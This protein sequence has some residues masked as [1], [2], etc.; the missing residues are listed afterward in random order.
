LWGGG[1]GGGG[2][3]KTKNLVYPNPPGVGGKGGGG[4]LVGGMGDPKRKPEGCRGKKT[5]K[6]K[7]A[8]KV[9]KTVESQ[10]TTD[11]KAKPLRGL[12]PERK[13]FILFNRCQPDKKTNG[14]GG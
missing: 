3:K 6:M 14:K 5:K 10:Q 7:L 4:V 13:K 12:K 1:P 9:G 2:E 8:V 11:P